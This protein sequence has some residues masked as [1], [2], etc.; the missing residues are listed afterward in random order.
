[1]KAITYQTTTLISEQETPA[2]PQKRDA[3]FHSML[4]RQALLRN[5][6]QSAIYDLVRGYEATTGFSV[7]RIDLQAKKRKVTLDAI[8]APR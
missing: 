1:M 3:S 2:A 4:L 6:I 5:Q 8:P 7:V